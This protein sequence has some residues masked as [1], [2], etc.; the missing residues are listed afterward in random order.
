MDID[1]TFSSFFNVTTLVMCLGI[2]LFTYIIRTVVE[3]LWKGAKTNIW[4]N[5][6]FLPLGAIVNGAILAFA[7]KMFP[8][9][10]P[11]L[12]ASKLGRAMYGAICGMASGFIFNRAKSLLS[13]LNPPSQLT[14]VAPPS[15]VVTESKNDD[16]K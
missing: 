3:A 2:Y 4:W 15:P 11:G 1:S 8:F 5:E 10:I 7:S 14:A 16:K 6:L 13:A 9:P 12:G